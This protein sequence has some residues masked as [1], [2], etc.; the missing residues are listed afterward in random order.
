MVPFDL[1]PPS[2]RADVWGR[3]TEVRET[4]LTHEGRKGRKIE[5]ALGVARPDNVGAST[6]IDRRRDSCVNAH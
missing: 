3:L 5:P 1:S 4:V 6:E 2:T